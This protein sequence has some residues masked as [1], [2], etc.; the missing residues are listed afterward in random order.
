MGTEKY[1]S[2]RK[3]IG[4]LKSSFEKY[5]NNCFGIKL[6]SSQDNHF[7]SKITQYNTIFQISQR[8]NLKYNTKFKIML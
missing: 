6:Y 2:E 1:S 3:L 4:Y 5:K 7:N 8:V